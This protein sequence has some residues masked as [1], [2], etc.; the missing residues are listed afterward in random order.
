[1]LAESI[2]I[3]EILKKPSRLINM[4][5]ANT[6]GIRSLFAIKPYDAYIARAIIQ[7]FNISVTHAA[8][9]RI[10]NTLYTLIA[11]EVMQR[12]IK[13]VTNGESYCKNSI[14]IVLGLTGRT[15]QTP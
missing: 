11:L 5:T 10:A 8:Q 3:P 9:V 6:M 4:L 7:P 13:N 15:Y 2:V 1:L 12:T 14:E